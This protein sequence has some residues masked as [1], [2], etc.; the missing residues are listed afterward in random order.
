[1]QRR[2]QRV[3]IN[4]AKIRKECKP[5]GPLLKGFRAFRE[6]FPRSSNP[7]KGEDQKAWFQGWDM[8]QEKQK[9]KENDSISPPRMP[10]R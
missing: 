5:Y 10:G 1:M 8:A 3:A 2:R 6:G 9:E 4:Q 7:F